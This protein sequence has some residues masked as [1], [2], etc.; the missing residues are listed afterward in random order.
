MNPQRTLLRNQQQ[1]SISVVEEPI[2][3]RLVDRVNV[4]TDSRLH[5]GIA[6]ATKR[7]DTVDEIGPLRRNG[8]RVPAQLVWRCRNLSERPAA[9]EARRIFFVRFMRY[10]R[11]DAVSPSAAIGMPGRGERGSAKLLC[12]EPQGM[13]LRRVLSLR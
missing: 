11:L 7:D 4:D 2:F 13:L 10:R 3:H 9:D 12:I 6:I 5:R 1:F 8:H